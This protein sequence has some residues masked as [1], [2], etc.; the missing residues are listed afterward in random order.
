ME[1]TTKIAIARTGTFIDSAGR[2]QTFTAAD[3][4]DI[5]A[6]YDPAKSEA[7]LVFGHPETDAPAYG[8]A[9]SLKREGE[10]LFAYVAHIPA[11]VRDLI[12]NRR[13]RYVS[14][15]L[16]PDR[17]RLLHV[18][19]LGAAAPAI[20]GLGP[21]SLAA[22]AVSI[23]F[24][25]KSEDGGTMPKELE[26][27]IDELTLENSQLKADV[28]QA[29]KDLKAAQ[30]KTADQAAEFAAYKENVCLS[31]R[32]SRVQAVVDAG[33]LQPAKFEEAVSFASALAG[34]ATPVEFSVDGKT[35]KISA[36]ERYL[37][38]LEARPV[39]ERFTSFATA[40]APGH[41]AVAAQQ[42]QPNDI[43][44]KL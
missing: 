12:H 3:L 30:Q 20:D 28:A 39:D 26:K 15:S 19:L 33:R 7:P 42:W 21:V 31:A 29:A 25:V 2:E 24:N 1:K 17:K 9:K 27:R 23:D 18:G 22:E 16:S 38:E 41:A 37:R 10:K 40:P 6:G 14:M 4:D 44:A 34:V 35:E 5:A 43:T 11:T 8:W 36:E 32:K 13:Y